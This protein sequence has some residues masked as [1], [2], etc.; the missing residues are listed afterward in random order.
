[1]ESREYNEDLKKIILDMTQ[2]ELQRSASN[3][4]A[5]R[6]IEGKVN[7]IIDD[8]LNEFNEE[9][10]DIQKYK[11]IIK[12]GSCQESFNDIGKLIKN[13]EIFKSKLELIKFAKYLQLEVNK[14]QSYKS[15]LKQ[16]AN[17]IYLNKDYYNKKYVYYFKDD[18][19]YVLEPENIKTHLIEEYRSRARNDMKSIA[20]I[21]NIETNESEGAED[22]RKKVI[23][24]IIKDKL[25]KIKH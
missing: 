3:K 4:G 9:A 8:S 15:I 2:E 1:M 6:Y 21:L 13:E 18:N 11:K 24:C 22:I 20:R 10:L 14:K 23:N 7:S 16:I 5:M 17:H 19:D 25:S 12:K